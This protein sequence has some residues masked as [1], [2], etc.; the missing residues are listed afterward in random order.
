[1]P[2]LRVAVD[3]EEGFSARLEDGA[4]VLRKGPKR[5]RITFPEMASVSRGRR[6]RYGRTMFWIGIALLP[7]LGFGAV[8]L[9]IYY[10]SAQG[11]LIIGFRKRKYALSG[12]EKT[13]RIIHEGIRHNRRDLDVY[14]EE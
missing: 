12:E 10:F 4:L 11:A 6:H 8:L 14:E 3:G 13:M 1:M 7:A 9:A 2:G 5:V